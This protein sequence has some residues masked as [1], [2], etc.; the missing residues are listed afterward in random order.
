M[1]V[2]TCS[3]WVPE[4]AFSQ[5]SW[6]PPWVGVSGGGSRGG[7]GLGR[8]DGAAPLQVTSEGQ[9]AAHFWTS[10]GAARRAFFLG[11]QVQKC[12]ALGDGSLHH[13][14]RRLGQ[15]PDRLQLHR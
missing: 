10:C 6:L 14:R 15:D 12:P 7:K 4:A 5:V 9:R 3:P 8:A 11:L 13:C 1:P 2:G